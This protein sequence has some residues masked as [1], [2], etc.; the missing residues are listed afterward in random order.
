MFLEELART[1]NVS[2]A[3]KKAHHSRQDAYKER[4]P[5]GKD[6]TGQLEAQEFAA[7]WEA[8]LEVATDMLELEARRRAEQGTLEPVFYQGEV[9]GKV[10]KYSD[11][12]LIFLLK[13]HRPEKFRET[14]RQENSGPGGAPQEIVLKVIRDNSASGA[15]DSSADA[16]PEAG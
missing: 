8:A 6:Q 7:A 3:A 13:A 5:E 11:T 4:N 15:G 16:P 1:G 12:L 14:I 9:C 2:A 10:K